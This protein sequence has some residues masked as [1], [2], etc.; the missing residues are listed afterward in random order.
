MTE[1]IIPKCSIDEDIPEDRDYSKNNVFTKL[2]LHKSNN[3][4]KYRSGKTRSII[5]LMLRSGSF[6]KMIR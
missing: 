2:F 6:I 3:F 5:L 4:E 1:T